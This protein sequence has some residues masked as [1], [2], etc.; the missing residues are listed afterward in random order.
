MILRIAGQFNMTDIVPPTL[1]TLPSHS[2]PPSPVTSSSFS[3]L[4]PELVQH[5][6]ESTVPLQ[7]YSET[8]K[9]RQETLLPFCLVSKLF[10]EIAKPLLFA[11]VSLPTTCHYTIWKAL[12]AERGG[13][14]ALV[15]EFVLP[16]E[17][18]GSIPLEPDWRQYVG[19]RLL[20]I[21]CDDSDV[22]LAKFAVLPSK[23]GFFA[24]LLIFRLTIICTT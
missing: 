19:L 8:Y 10:Y 22:D 23:F 15:R 14:P 12:E 1:A 11:V 24:R 5:I 13:H 16:E 9:P 6:I 20:V 2:S 21:E 7:Y 4:P 17:G 18:S 3:K